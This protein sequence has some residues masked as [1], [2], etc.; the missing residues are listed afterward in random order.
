MFATIVLCCLAKMTVV[1]AN[2]GCH[3]SKDAKI[4]IIKSTNLCYFACTKT[5]SQSGVA[6]K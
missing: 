2:N 1:R 3:Q 6:P 5:A 4:A